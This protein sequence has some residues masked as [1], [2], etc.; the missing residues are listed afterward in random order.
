MKQIQLDTSI[1]D[2]LFENKNYVYSLL[3]HDSEQDILFTK[4]SHFKYLS[5]FYVLFPAQLLDS[6]SLI[7][8]DT[9]F[10]TFNKSNKKITKV[11]L[12]NRSMFI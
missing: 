7:K 1:I 12:S 10:Y 6:N 8:I 3:Y 5:Q 9:N 4:L 11:D 2:L